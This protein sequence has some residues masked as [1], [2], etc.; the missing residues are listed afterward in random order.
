[1]EAY[2]QLFNAVVNELNTDYNTIQ[3]ANRI[4]K[5][6]WNCYRGNVLEDPYRVVPINGK[7]NFCKQTLNAHQYIGEFN[8]VFGSFQFDI[9]NRIGLFKKV[10]DVEK[11]NGINRHYFWSCGKMRPLEKN[12]IEVFDMKP[13]R[14]KDGKYTYKGLKIDQLKEVCKMNGIKGL[15]KMDKT[16]LVRSLIKC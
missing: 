1:M 10:K 2:N 12:G 4:F 16:E 14:T 5:R 7:Y 9:R 13:E 8:C 3:N 6:N 11:I 15:S